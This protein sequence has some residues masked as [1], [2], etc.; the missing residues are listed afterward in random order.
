VWFTQAYAMP[1]CSPTRASILT[2]RHAARLHL[3][4]W[5]E[6]ALQPPRDQPLLPPPAIADLPAAEVTLAEVLKGAGYL[7]FHVGKWHLGD[8]AHSPET[9][10]FD[11]NI[12]GT[13]WGAP[14]TYCYPFRGPLFPQ[15]D[16]A[17]INRL[18]AEL[19]RG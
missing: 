10:G 5:G 17:Q 1:V 14:A 6:G 13:H 15:A 2:G 19:G 12:G 18:D 9:Q 8:A 7:A 3:T 16:A 4:I 11:L